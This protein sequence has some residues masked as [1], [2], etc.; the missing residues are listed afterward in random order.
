V[1]AV[2]AALSSELI[3]AKLDHSFLVSVFHFH[4]KF[5]FKAA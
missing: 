3:T 2:T 1:Q 5:H 4:T